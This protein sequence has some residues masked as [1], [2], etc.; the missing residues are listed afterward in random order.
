MA[1]NSRTFTSI[2]D[3]VDN[4]TSKFDAIQKRANSIS[5]RT[6][7][8]GFDFNQSKTGQALDNIQKKVNDTTSTT[9]SWNNALGRAAGVADKTASST[10]KI[11]NEAQ[12]T[13]GFLGSMQSKLENVGGVADKLRDKFG[14][15]TGLLAGGSIGGMSWLNAMASEKADKSLDRRLARMHLDTKPIDDFIGKAEGT[16]YTTTGA[17]QDITEALLVRT[18]L[19]GSKMESATKAIE[20]L[21]FQNSYDLNKKG[22]NSAEGLADLLTKKKLG[23]GDKQTLIDLGITGTS[24][25]SRLRSAE[26][27]AKGIDETTL[28]KEDPYQAFLNRL[29]ETSKKVGKTMIEPMNM[30]L[31]KTNDLLDLVNNIPGAPGLI[32]LVAVMTAAAGGASL[33]LTVLQ[34]LGGVLKGLKLGEAVG[35][36]SRLQKLFSGGGSLSALMNPYV[37]LAALA[38]ILIV[39]AYRTGVLGKAWDKFIVFNTTSLTYQTRI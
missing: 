33:L 39:V 4:F 12:R 25:T 36:M 30:V 8:V 21:Y 35:G 2:F 32:A 6:F 9:N 24:A 18:K 15:I 31:G 28:A 1:E 11:G 29:S 16:G 37:A 17:R 27:Q 23:P 38:A 22:I 19:R 34:P 26:K 14:A 10:Q 13:T 20:D 5:E 7:K 3:L